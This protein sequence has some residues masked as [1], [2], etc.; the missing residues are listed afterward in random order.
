MK[1][2]GIS[3]SLMSNGNT[4]RMVKTLL[5]KSGNESESVNL[6]I[7]RYALYVLPKADN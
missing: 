3:G 4:D 1:V 5:G 7:L 6:N 2:I